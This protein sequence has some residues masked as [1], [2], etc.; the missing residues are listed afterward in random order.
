MPGRHGSSCADLK[1][2]MSENETITAI[3]GDG[4]L[5][6]IDK[7]DAHVRNIRHVA[8]SVFVLEG[9]RLLLQKRATGKY[10]S[11]GLWANSC[12]SHPRWN[13][14]VETCAARRLREELGWSV[15]LTKFGTIA[16]TAKVGALFENEVAHCFFGRV[17][18]G[19]SVEN[20]NIQ[21]VAAV[22]WRTLSQIAEDLETEPQQFTE[23]FRIYITR[24]L[25]MIGPLAQ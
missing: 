2:S 5:Y 19:M 10:H 6:P 8:I 17:E 13:E 4:T 9:G 7:L 21:E 16:Y 22:E 20:F 24:H 15:P 25:D 1:R 3:A 14:S 12:C 18:P 23:W 11:A